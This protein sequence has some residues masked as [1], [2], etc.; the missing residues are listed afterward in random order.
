MVIVTQTQARENVIEKH[1]EM[2]Q[3]MYIK[4]KEAFDYLYAQGHVD[5]NTF[6]DLCSIS[7]GKEM[8]GVVRSLINLDFIIKDGTYILSTPKFRKTYALLNKNT[9]VEKV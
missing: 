8:S 5:S 3:S 6:K 4:W 7:D 2:L 1:T 9:E